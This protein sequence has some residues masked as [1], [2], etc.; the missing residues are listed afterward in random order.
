[1]IRSLATVRRCARSVLVPL[2]ASVATLD[3]Q[4]TGTVSRVSAGV[5]FNASHPRGEFDAVA[6]AGWGLGGNV[7]V[8][9][10]QNALLNWRTDAAFQIGGLLGEIVS[11]GLSGG[12]NNQ[13]NR[14]SSSNDVVSLVTG[15][16]LMSAS[17]AFMPY[18]AALGGFSVFWTS[19]SARRAGVNQPAI[20]TTTNNSLT[21][22]YGGTA[23]F[24][25]LLHE[26]RRHVHM[27]AGMRFLRHDAIDYVTADEARESIVERRA[28]Q[29]VRSR[30]DLNTFYLGV[31]IGAPRNTGLPPR[32][33]R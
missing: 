4:G 10:D 29:A 23:G 26:G 22:A 32:A 9:L 6:S 13:D 19:H 24:Y 16:Q 14:S 25:L 7:L 8:R 20:V 28:P 12:V 2:V 21:W 30:A 5:S 11:E 31:Q 15:P 33:G 1:M 27:D 18:V 3:A 17:R